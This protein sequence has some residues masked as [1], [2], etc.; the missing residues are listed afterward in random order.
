[1][2]ESTVFGES[3]GIVALD[4]HVLSEAVLDVPIILTFFSEGS[5]RGVNCLDCIVT[6]HIAWLISLYLN[7]CSA[8][9]VS[10]YPTCSRRR[11]P[12]LS[13]A[14]HVLSTQSNCNFECEHR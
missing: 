14:A 9:A 3:D 11:L 12:V 5:A 8:I 4:V 6:T 1:M 7:A 2:N 10:L 13:F